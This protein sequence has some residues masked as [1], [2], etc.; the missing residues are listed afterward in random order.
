MTL[1]VRE[2]R[3]LLVGIPGA[4]EVRFACSSYK[5]AAELTSVKLN[6]P[7]IERPKG[8]KRPESVTMRFWSV[9]L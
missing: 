2:L 8:K 7:C 1:T 6:V 4:T 5:G 3:K 9:K